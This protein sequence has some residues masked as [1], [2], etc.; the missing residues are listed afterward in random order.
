M[1]ASKSKP[2]EY[3][4]KQWIN[5]EDTNCCFDCRK[6]FS[7]TRRR[8]HCRCCGEIYCSECWGAL[9]ML[10]PDYGYTAEVP[11][12]NACE[13]LFAG[14][15]KFLRLPR[16]IV[17]TRAL[18]D[19]S[20]RTE[21]PPLSKENVA[22]S[23]F[24]VFFVKVAHWRPF[25]DVTHLQ[26]SITLRTANGHN[27]SHFNQVNTHSPNVQKPKPGLVPT[28]SNLSFDTKRGLLAAQ[29]RGSGDML[30]DE[31]EERSENG[32][33][34]TSEGSSKRKNRQDTLLAAPTGTASSG[35]GTIADAT[36]GLQLDI[37]WTLPLDALL[38]VMLDA[39]EDGDYITLETAQELYRVQ[40]AD[41][42]GPITAEQKQNSA[43]GAFHLLRKSSSA[44]K[45][46]PVERS[47]AIGVDAKDEGGDD[48]PKAQS[49]PVQ[50]TVK[51]EKKRVSMAREENND[52][53]PSA[54]ESGSSSVT[55]GGPVNSCSNHADV[56]TSKPL[57]GAVF[58]PNEADTRNL[59]MELQVAVK[60][61]M[62][63]QK[64]KE[65]KR[66]GGGGAAT[67]P[68]SSGGIPR[69]PGAASRSN[70]SFASQQ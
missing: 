62:E 1:G 9:V 10:P 23:S 31:G 28:L 57:S 36:K 58:T 7:A 35:E 5:D 53:G 18:K 4:K 26:F 48:S 8:H 60:I 37:A 13:M 6:I 65:A 68:H 11:V 64:A 34:T 59:F 20:S 39:H 50:S 49:F 14:S 30:A 27:S 29:R 56:I 54:G 2:S 33:K 61:M 52:D 25:T 43:E 24:E 46:R 40:C 63:R 12:C 70:R 17:L 41:I 51:K 19:S 16:R 55:S 47:R 67:S 45:R 44:T 42:Q 15:L 38:R 32:A 66:R 69:S 21:Q 3:V 22:K